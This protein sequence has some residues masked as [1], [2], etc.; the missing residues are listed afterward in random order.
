VVA[1]GCIAGCIVFLVEREGQPELF[2]KLSS[3]I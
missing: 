1:V 3:S 2:G